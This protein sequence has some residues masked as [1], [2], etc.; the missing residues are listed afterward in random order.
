MT[1]SGKVARTTKGL[2]TILTVGALAALLSTLGALADIAIG[3]ITG[4]SVSALPPDAAGRLAQLAVTPLLGLYNLDF[5]NLV[6]TLLMVPALYASWL[7]LRREGPAAGLALVFGIIAAAVFVANNSALAMLG[8]SGDWARADSSRRALL[9]AAGEALLAKGA[10]GSP[11]VLLGFLLSTIANLILSAAMLRTKAFRIATGIL[12][13]GGNLLLG[14]YLILVTFL[15]Q[16]KE[17]AMA[18]AAPGGLLAIGWMCMIALRLLRFS[19]VA[20]VD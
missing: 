2:S 3:T 6:N 8:L 14:A 19:R 1:D 13:I 5:L 18:F 11:G 10:H 20:E 4:G 15:P 16:V 7:A 12:G 9:A 17:M